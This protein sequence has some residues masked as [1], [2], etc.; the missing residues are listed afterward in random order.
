ML[1]VIFKQHDEV[2]MEISTNSPLTGNWTDQEKRQKKIDDITLE[3][4]NISAQ[5]IYD[6]INYFTDKAKIELADDKSITF[7]IIGGRYKVC[8]GTTFGHQQCNICEPLM[9]FQNYNM[10]AIKNLKNDKYFRTSTLMQ[11]YIS[12]HKFFGCDPLYRID[13]ALACEVLD[14]T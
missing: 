4:L 13:P 9:L 12:V 1:R 2:C 10:G 6:R 8:W 3:K 11:H 7:T 5:E 14:L